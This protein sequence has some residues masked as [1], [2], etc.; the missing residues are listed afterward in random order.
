MGGF[1]AFFSQT[2]DFSL[3]LPTIKAMIV[4]PFSV[5][6]LLLENNGWELQWGQSQEMGFQ[7]LQ[8]DVTLRSK[9]VDNY[10]FLHC[11]N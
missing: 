6:T 3:P 7:M 11:V 9:F 10:S 2:I 4:V 1:W 8:D 5:T